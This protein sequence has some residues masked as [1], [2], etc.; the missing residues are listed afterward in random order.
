MEK[1]K[2]WPA[3]WRAIVLLVVGSVMGANLIAPA[4]AHIGSWT[5]N[6]TVH[7]KPKTDARYYTKTA[8][9]NR[10]ARGVNAGLAGSIPTTESPA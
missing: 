5:H 1:R 3:G 9:A 7:I 6:W 10:L 2:I 4:V 8:T